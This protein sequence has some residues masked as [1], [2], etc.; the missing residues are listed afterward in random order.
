MPWLL[1]WLLDDYGF[2]T[3]LRVWAV[4]VVRLSHPDLVP[5]TIPLTS[6]QAILSVPSIYVLKNRLPIAATR[7]SR[8]ID[9]SFLRLPPFWIFQVLRTT[10]QT[11]AP[12]TDNHT[13]HF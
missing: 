7:T 11:D 4:V 5:T 1:Q 10:P 6:S 3:A 13:H 12:L 8:P 2:R 9:W